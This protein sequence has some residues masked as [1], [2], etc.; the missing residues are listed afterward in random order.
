MQNVNPGKAALLLQHLPGAYEEWWFSGLHRRLLMKLRILTAS[1]LAFSLALP[2]VS[3]AQHDDHGRDD[4]GGAHGQPA[5]HG[6]GPGARHDAPRPMPARDDHRA[7][8]RGAGPDHAFMRGGRLPQNSRSNQYVVD[9]WRGHHLSA[10][11]RGYHWVQTGADYVLV[12]VATGI[13][14]QVLLNQ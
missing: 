6:P 11:P 12:A 8:G 2:A 10:P 1:L 14:A 7:D 9:D 5:D 13:I 4:R 3:M